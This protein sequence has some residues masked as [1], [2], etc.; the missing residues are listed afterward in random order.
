MQ[1]ATLTADLFLSV[2]G[3]ARGEQSPGYFGY[4]GP[5][6]EQWIFE[7]M[8]RPQHVIMGRR[9]YAALAGLPPEHRD[10]G[11]FRMRQLPTT[12]FSRTLTTAEW[13]NATIEPRDLVE[14]VRS[15]KEAGAVPLRTMGS[16]SVVKQLFN[17]G[18]VDRLRLM[19][20]PLLVGPG[21]RESAFEAVA[22]A[23]LSLLAHRV[24]DNRILL[25][26][27]A[28]TARPIPHLPGGD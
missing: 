15:L 19:V 23:D 13:P 24:L 10:E 7:E 14:S 21:G 26:E 4:F 11:Y 17:A 16:L 28:P 3:W 8:A 20:F 25:S 12:V 1:T 2:D 27:Y 6:L 9:T 18:L 22:D 5:E